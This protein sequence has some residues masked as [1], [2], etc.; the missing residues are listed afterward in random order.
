[1][2]CH[3]PERARNLAAGPLVLPK[4]LQRPD[5]RELDD[6]VFEMLGVS[7]SGERSELID[8]LYEATSQYFRDIR[9]V[10]IE[11]MEQRARSEGTRLNVHDLAADIW[12]AVELNDSLSVGQWLIEI[13]QADVWVDVPEERPA[14]LLDSPLFPDHTVYFGR[15]RKEQVHC[16][17]RSQAQ[18]VL[19][20]AELGVSGRL[21]IPSGT[22]PPKGLLG[23]C[24]PDKTG[25]PPASIGHVR[26][27]LAWSPSRRSPSAATGRRSRLGPGSAAA[28]FG[29]RNGCAS[30]GEGVDSCR[31]RSQIGNS[32]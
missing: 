3:S 17:S 27:R 9:V 31:Q 12:D 21:K 14:V 22:E 24:S 16:G 15:S 5:R 10:E 1:M 25:T 30:P 18:L 7:D 28:S 11:K 26:H 2:D 8:C 29:W 20:L 23:R 19:H 13:P 4:E 32:R 6:A